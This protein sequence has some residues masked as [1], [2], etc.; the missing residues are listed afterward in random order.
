[1]STKEDQIKEQ[2]EYYLSDENLEKDE[3]F[4]KEIESCSDVSN[5]FIK[6][7]FEL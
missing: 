7:F 3:F 4:R 2:I 6:A 1:M 5:N